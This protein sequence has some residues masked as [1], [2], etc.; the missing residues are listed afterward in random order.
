M[1]ASTKSPCTN[2]LQYHHKDFG[3]KDCDVCLKGTGIDLKQKI[4]RTHH[5]MI[6]CYSCYECQTGTYQNESY[7]IERCKPCNTCTNQRILR[8]CSTTENAICGNCLPGHQV[9]Y[10]NGSDVCEKIENS[11]ESLY[12][13]LTIVL[14]FLLLLVILSFIWLK[15]KKI[16]E[17]V[18]PNNFKWKT[19]LEPGK[20]VKNHGQRIFSGCPNNFKLK[21]CLKPEKK[22]KNHEEIIFSACSMDPDRISEACSMDPDRISEANKEKFEV[23]DD[24]TFALNIGNDWI[25]VARCLNFTESG[26]QEIEDNQKLLR[27][28][29][30]CMIRTYRQIHC[31]QNDEDL[32]KALISIKQYKLLK[33]KQTIS[34]VKPGE[35]DPLHC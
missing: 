34:E 29:A 16:I 14:G 5:G 25:Y 9:K 21:N 4:N 2:I 13:I 20:H 17:K 35:A 8:N 27:D 6:S 19:C 28:R 18:C 22:V 32:I 15:R 12:M 26:I 33:T 31:S 23:V 24:S 3:C 11:Y 10:I 30:F 1:P 7:V